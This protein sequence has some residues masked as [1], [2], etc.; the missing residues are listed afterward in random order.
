VAIARRCRL[1]EYDAFLTI[2]LR[3]M[4][5]MVQK[6]DFAEDANRFVNSMMNK[7][8][9]N[10]VHISSYQSYDMTLFL[11]AFV[12]KFPVQAPQ[13]LKWYMSNFSEAQ[14]N[15]RERHF[16]VTFLTTAVEHY[17]DPRPGHFDPIIRPVFLLA[18]R[19]LKSCPLGLL[20][21][22]SDAVCLLTMCWRRCPSGCNGM[23]RGL[24]KTLEWVKSMEKGLQEIDIGQKVLRF[25]PKIARLWTL[26]HSTNFPTADSRRI[27]CDKD[28]FK[29]ILVFMPFPA[30]CVEQGEILDRLMTLCF[31]PGYEFI[32]KELCRICAEFLVLTKQEMREFDFDSKLQ[33]K[34]HFIGK[35]YL[36]GEGSEKLLKWVKDKLINQRVGGRDL[37]E[38]LAKL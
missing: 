31:M 29:S 16:Y 32:V 3:V 21:R 9:P 1:L 13:A 5:K 36:T 24:A 7:Q 14:M 2:S 19:D 22:A 34:L 15:D 37:D 25:L 12:K 11:Q 28:E 30:S 26:V 8:W 38:M 17:P 20:T 33:K 27:P 23:E 18:Y 10:L 35:K 4:R 6:F